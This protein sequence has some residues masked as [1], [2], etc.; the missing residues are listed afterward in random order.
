MGIHTIEENEYPIML[1]KIGKDAPKQLY[2]KGVWDE[3]IFS[4]CLA[5]VGSRLLTTYGRQA[6]GK[7]VTELAAARKTLHPGIT[8][9]WGFWA[10]D[11]SS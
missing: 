2:Y 11:V 9:S 8:C 6:S 5:V 1:K 10:Q 7:L 3:E 4:N